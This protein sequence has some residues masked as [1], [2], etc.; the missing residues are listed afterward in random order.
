MNKRRLMAWVLLVVMMI[1]LLPHALFANDALLPVEGTIE[2][3]VLSTPDPNGGQVTPDVEI[4]WKDDGR[5]SVTSGGVT[6]SFLHYQIRLTD[7][8]EKKTHYSEG[9]KTTSV[10]LQDLKFGF[11][12]Y[13]NKPIG[14]AYAVENGKVYQVEI[15]P[16]YTYSVNKPDGSSEPR[17]DVPTATPQSMYFITDFDAAMQDTE[18]GLMMTWEYIPGA[19]Y[20]VAYTL[21]DKKTVSEF[22]QGIDGTIPVIRD[23]VTSQ[24]AAQSLIVENGKTKVKYTISP[25]TPGQIYSAYVVVSNYKIAGSLKKPVMN[26]TTGLK[27]PK[28]VKAIPAIEIRV[29]NVGNERIKISWNFQSWVGL[30]GSLQKIIVYGKGINENVFTP[31]LEIPTTNMTVESAILDEP[32]KETYYYLDF[33]F[34]DKAG[35][36]YTIKSKTVF[37]TPFVLREEPL[38]PH[39]PKPYA[40]HMKDQIEQEGTKSDYL[41]SEDH[42][43]PITDLT[44]KENTFHSKLNENGGLQIVWDLPKKVVD[45]TKENDFDL[46]YDLWITD[47]K[48][49]V[50]NNVPPV[51]ENVKIGAEDKASQ[52]LSYTD[53]TP[54]GL[55]YLVQNY[56]SLSGKVMPIKANKTYYIKMVAKRAYGSD[57][58]RSQPTVVSI[59]I[60]KNGD[61]ARPPVLGKPPLQLDHTTTQT[62]TIKWR[63]QWYEILARDLSMYADPDEKVLGQMGSGRVYLDQPIATTGAAIHFKF[64]EGRKEYTLYEEDYVKEVKEKVGLERYKRDYYDRKLSLGADVSYETKVVPYN[65]VLGQLGS[66]EGIEQWVA[67]QGD[68]E[69]WAPINPVD[70]AD[71]NKGWKLHTVEGLTPNTKYVMM[72]RAYR[73]VDGE[74]LSQTFPSYVI[75]TT[76]SDYVSPEP[77]PKVPELYLESK[78]DTSLAV[79]FTYNKQFDYEVVYSRKDDPSTAMTWAFKVSDDPTNK[80]YIP[81]GGKAIVTINGLFPETTYNVWIRA[82]QKK[83]E[84]VSAWSNPVTAKTDAIRAP[85]VPTGLGP[86]AYQSIVEINQDFPPIGKDYIT[87]EWTKDPNDQGVQTEGSMEKHYEY[88]LEFADNVEFMD[89][90]SVTV[91]DKNGEQASK[92][93]EILAKNMVKFNQLASNRPYYVRVKARIVLTDTETKRILTKESDF[94]KGVRILTKKS[95]DE[96]DGGEN[97]NIVIYPDAIEENYSNG[98]WTWEICDAQTIISEII[99]KKDYFLTVDMTLYNGRAD[100]LVRK[101][102]VPKSVWDALVGQKMELKVITSY[103]VYQIPAQAMSYAT[104]GMNAKQMIELTFS[105]TYLYDVM[106]IAKPYPYTFKKA[107]RLEIRIEG[108]QEPVSRLDTML[109]AELKLDFAGD[110]LYNNIQAHTYDAK[111]GSWVRE[112]SSV[113]TR[114]DGTYI[115]FSTPRLGVYGLY[116]VTDYTPPSGASY[117]MSQLLGRYEITGLGSTYRKNDQVHSDQYIQL[118]LGVAQNKS[119][120]DLTTP[121][122]NDARE[123]ARAAQLYISRQDGFVTQ[124]QAISGVVRLYELRS[125]SKIKAS[126]NRVSGV[127]P[128]YK[129][130]IGKAYAIGLIDGINAAAP[131]TYSQLCD[132]MIQVLP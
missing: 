61:I 10:K 74:K 32:K 58:A 108:R 116:S 30:D 130:A 19:D 111:T 91:S 36:L 52:V 82:K 67:K 39:I 75:A 27:G 9:R 101:V 26:E 5:G 121:P 54:V 124:E 98:T 103:G 29:N 24:V 51:Y 25:A 15:I 23:T 90:L 57:Y 17:Y 88:T 79:W 63:E 87:V 127:S 62:A 41:V 97:D 73:M 94:S 105:K 14:D 7:L 120:I 47:D 45:G 28:V 60:D 126:A 38:K 71:T 18:D 107:E 110:Y 129:E 37:Y 35:K 12:S 49:M 59:T 132:W 100:A 1:N 80:D 70:G 125:G 42:T 11:D 77:T 102:R 85:Q 65:D 95:D 48:K 34:K 33:I 64:E 92:A 72:I 68:Q 78:T 81:D 76:L 40:D 46:S 31:K 86:A 66:G 114:S 6:Y 83:G 50:E 4:K 109:R 43:R 93:A 21:A 89:A 119:V 106:A 55:K 84:Q 128:A 113:Q 44:F 56:I 123:K 22:G 96:Y 112:A 2:I 16:V 104:Q 115:G 20:E 117:S 69:G 13:G 53:Q 99:G 122:S 118:I 3:T 8:V 131:V